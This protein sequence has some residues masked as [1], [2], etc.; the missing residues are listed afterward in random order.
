MSSVPA[1]VPG[2][3]P[4]HRH[5]TP[6]VTHPDLIRDPAA[7]IAAAATNPA[8]S[9]RALRVYIVATTYDRGVSAEAVAATL[10]GLTESQAARLL[11]DLVS[12]GLLEK[13]L[14][15]VGYKPGGTRTR[16]GFYTLVG[17]EHA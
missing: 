3:T 11:G 10:P 12:A 6:G 17:G 1:R 8:V 5:N 2:F 13:R 14:R 9:D 7:L 15:T 4:A 16:R